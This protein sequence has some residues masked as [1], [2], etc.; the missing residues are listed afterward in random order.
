MRLRIFS[1][2]SFQ[3]RGETHLEANPGKQALNK[4]SSKDISCICLTIT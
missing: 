4:L 3:I 1:F 2:R